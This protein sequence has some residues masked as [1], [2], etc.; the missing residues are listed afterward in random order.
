MRSW[1]TRFDTLPTSPPVSP[2]LCD[3][4][5]GPQSSALDDPS[6]PKLTEKKED[7]MPH[8]ASVFVGRSSLSST[9]SPFLS[10]TFT[11]QPS[12]RH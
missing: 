7:K 8:D 4:A 12:F 6:D 9:F 1:G 11:L 2:P 10:L 3:P 5:V